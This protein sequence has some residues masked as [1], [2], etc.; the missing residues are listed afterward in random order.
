MSS[1]EWH[2][3]PRSVADQVPGGVGAPLES[4]ETRLPS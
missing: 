1:V 2:A 3:Q 4:V